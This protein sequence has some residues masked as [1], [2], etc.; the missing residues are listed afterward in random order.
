M[1]T[2][3]SGRLV[4]SSTT[5]A[6]AMVAVEAAAAAPDTSEVASP[7]TGLV[8]ELSPLDLFT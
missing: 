5:A 8:H 3:P 2:Q 4:S 1:A 7:D 6:A